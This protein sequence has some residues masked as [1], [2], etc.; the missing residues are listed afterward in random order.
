MT[1]INSLLRLPEELLQDVIDRLE[2]PALKAL[3]LSSRWG[4]QTATPRIWRNVELVDCRTDRRVYDEQGRCV[5][6]LSDEHDDTPLIRIL[7]I[8]A[9]CV[10]DAGERDGYLTIKPEAHR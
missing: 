5:D 4:Y 9:R 7:I 8:L 3:S 10:R 6:E 2:R 1:K